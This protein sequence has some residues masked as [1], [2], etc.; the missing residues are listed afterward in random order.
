MLKMTA[1]IART[2]LGVSVYEAILE[3]ILSGELPSG[4]ELS[5]VSLARE[6]RVSRT[7]I[8]EAIKKLAKD[9]LIVHESG[10]RPQVARFGPPEVAELYTMR[11]IL[12]CAAVERA[13]TRMDDREI[14]DLR[15]RADGLAASGASKEAEWKRRALEFD[16]HFHDT[17]ARASGC[18][19]LHE[20]VRRY[21]LLVRAFCRITGSAQNLRQAMGEHLRILEALEARDAPGA[22]EA[23][24]AHIDARLG[25]VMKEAA[26]EEP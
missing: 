26:P 3:N 12:E 4:T 9:G 20:D 5:E 23:M 2:Y 1:P 17:L 22:R 10:R 7:P 13:A 11:K 19:R 16:Q 6:L 21:R 24:A 14:R 8:H 25:V 15:K 18:V